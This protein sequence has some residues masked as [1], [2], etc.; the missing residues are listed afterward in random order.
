MLK[1]ASQIYPGNC[2]RARSG[3]VKLAKTFHPDVCT[4]V[5]IHHN[6]DSKL[7]KRLSEMM[8]SKYANVV[9]NL[10]TGT[11]AKPRDDSRDPTDL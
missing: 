1:E 10:C 11:N 8:I 7:V 3:L 5:A 6:C 2:K 4:K 9:N